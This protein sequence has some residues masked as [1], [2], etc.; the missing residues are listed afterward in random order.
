MDGKLWGRSEPHKEGTPVAQWPK[1]CPGGHS[2]GLIALYR[3][4]VIRVE[5]KQPFHWDVSCG[6]V[7][8]EDWHEQGCLSPP[9]VTLQVEQKEAP[10]PALHSACGLAAHLCL[11]RLP[12]SASSSLFA[13]TAFGNVSS[14]WTAEYSVWWLWNFLPVIHIL[15]NWKLE[16]DGRCQ[17]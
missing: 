11:E 16:G 5:A 13:L 3:V 17:C 1:V 2:L 14:P 7:A 4:Q 12:A 9:L 10:S 15:V 6:S 8:Q